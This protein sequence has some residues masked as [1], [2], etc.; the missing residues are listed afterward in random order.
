MGGGGEHLQKVKIRITFMFTRSQSMTSKAMTHS[1]ESNT[2]E[3][4]FHPSLIGG[5][6]TR[7]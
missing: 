3:C 1:V 6:N 5:I 4:L 7:S 2:S